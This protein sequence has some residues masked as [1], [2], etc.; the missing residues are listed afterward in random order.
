MLMVDDDVVMPS[1]NFS[2]KA[3][4]AATDDEVALVLVGKHATPTRQVL[5]TLIRSKSSPTTLHVPGVV[6]S[7]GFQPMLSSAS[8]LI[9]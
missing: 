7:L 6:E 5:H 3:I 2:S 1:F 8:A 9:G 4:T